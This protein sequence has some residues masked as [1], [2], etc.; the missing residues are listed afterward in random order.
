MFNPPA[1]CKEPYEHTR[2]LPILE[3]IDDY[4]HYIGR[5]DIT[6]Q[7]RAGFTT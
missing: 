6:D 2:I 5:V 1:G 4:N 7:L 3:A